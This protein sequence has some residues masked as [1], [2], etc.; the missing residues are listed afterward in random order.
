M[1]DGETFNYERKEEY[2][3]ATMEFDPEEGLIR[4]ETLMRKAEKR[5]NRYMMEYD[6][7][8]CIE[9]IGLS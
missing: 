8:N 9:I 2:Q 3:I 5:E 4:G 1:D 6:F 7:A